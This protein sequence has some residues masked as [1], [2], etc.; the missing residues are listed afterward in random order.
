MG[1]TDEILALLIEKLLGI[2]VQFSEIM[3]TAVGVG[4][5]LALESYDKGPGR[6]AIPQHTKMYVFATLDQVCTTCIVGF[7][8]PSTNQRQTS[9]KESRQPLGWHRSKR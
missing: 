6:N 4:V 8:R 5:Y 7:Y 1:G 9:V 3:G 2:P